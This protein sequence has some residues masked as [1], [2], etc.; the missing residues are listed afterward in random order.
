MVLMSR[1][2]VDNYYTYIML[3]GELFFICVFK[4]RKHN[5]IHLYFVI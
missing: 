2:T 1:T 5:E 4:F 3:N